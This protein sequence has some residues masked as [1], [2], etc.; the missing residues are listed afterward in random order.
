MIKTFWLA[1]MGEKEIGLMFKWK[2]N[3]PKT[4]IPGPHSKKIKWSV[5]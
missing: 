4:K 2:N 1:V 3:L 5:P